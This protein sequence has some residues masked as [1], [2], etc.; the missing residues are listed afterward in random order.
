MFG[1]IL[2]GWSRRK[3]ST[4]LSLNCLPSLPDRC[5][6]GGKLWFC[7]RPMLYTVPSITHYR[8]STLSER[9]CP[10]VPPLE[11]PFIQDCFA[12]CLKHEEDIP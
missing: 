2:S 3:L 7:S 6:G 9:S 11:N 8:S 5:L 4:T 1:S 10:D 12:T